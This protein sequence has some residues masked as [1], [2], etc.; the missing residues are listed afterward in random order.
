MSR[1]QL[2]GNLC[3]A[4]TVAIGVAAL[5]VWAYCQ[6]PPDKAVALKLSKWE[7]SHHTKKRCDEYRKRE[8]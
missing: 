2:I 7:C 3:G 1:T 5:I 6:T 4:G 8:K